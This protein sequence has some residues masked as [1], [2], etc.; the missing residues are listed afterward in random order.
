MLFPGMHSSTRVHQQKRVAVRLAAAARFSVD[1][2]CYRVGHHPHPVSE[3]A[4]AFRVSL[5]RCT[6]DSRLRTRATLPAPNLGFCNGEDHW[7]KRP[8]N[9]RS[10]RL[11]I[12]E[13]GDDQPLV[14]DRE[15]GRR[16]HRPPP[17]MQ[18]LPITVA[19]GDPGAPCNHRV[20]T[21]ADVCG[22]SWDL[23]VEL[24]GPP[25]PPVSSMAPPINRGVGSD[26]PNI[27][28]DPH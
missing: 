4:T 15:V 5:T 13:A 19:A 25:R 23:I 11:T 17:M 14:A 9:L 21:Y 24:D 22:P 8:G 2:K 1:I 18:C 27:R 10:E 12:A 28:A 16:F 7:S 26:F 3:P 6:S 20:S